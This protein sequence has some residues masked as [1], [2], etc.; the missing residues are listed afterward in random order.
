MFPCCRFRG[1]AVWRISCIVRP[2]GVGTFENITGRAP[3]DG[4]CRCSS[5]QPQIYRLAG[6]RIRRRQIIAFTHFPGAAGGYPFRQMCRW[7]NQSLSANRRQSDVN[8][9]AMACLAVQQSNI[10]LTST[11]PVAVDFAPFG[12]GQFC[13]ADASIVAYCC[14]R[15]QAAYLCPV[16]RQ[17]IIMWR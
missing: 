17:S 3:L 4:I 7:D 9:D 12:K 5:H 10:L 6:F 14:D 15:P 13:N 1:I 16:K 2:V 11:S 8:A